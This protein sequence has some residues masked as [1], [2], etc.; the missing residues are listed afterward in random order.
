MSTSL[1]T[2]ALSCCFLSSPFPAA[3]RQTRSTLVFNNR[4]NSSDF[5][6]SALP[7]VSGGLQLH[8]S[9]PSLLHSKKLLK[10]ITFVGWQLIKQSHHSEKKGNCVKVR[11][12]AQLLNSKNVCQAGF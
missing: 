9:S 8:L 4:G 3:L 10:E 7:R 6:Q 11:L 1:D 5:D 12:W 2:A